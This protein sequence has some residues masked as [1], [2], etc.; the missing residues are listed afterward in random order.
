[1]YLFA[2]NI[3]L[4]FDTF[5]YSLSHCQFR[6]ET[7]ERQSDNRGKPGFHH[8]CHGFGEESI[9]ETKENIFYF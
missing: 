6:V 4:Y 7:S 5:Q 1:M 3:R 2:G 8:I 9:T